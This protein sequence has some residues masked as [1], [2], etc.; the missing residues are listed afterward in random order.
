MLEPKSCR[1]LQTE[2]RLERNLFV[3]LSARDDVASIEEQSPKVEFIDPSGKTRSH[4]FDALATMVDGRRIAIDVK[5]A[6]RVVSS[7]IEGIQQAIR[8]QHGTAVADVFVI[9]TEA[10]IHPDD[11]ADAE[12]LLRAR[13]SPDPDA[14]G[15]VAGLILPHGGAQCVADLVRASGLLSVAFHAIVR[16]VGSGVLSVVGDERLSYASRIV[17]RPIATE[18]AR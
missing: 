3:I 13:R 6:A 9:R 18:V 5:P 17:R 1:E 2:S 7:G 16:L 15:I 8:E 10:H 12:L 11:L 14:D 4:V